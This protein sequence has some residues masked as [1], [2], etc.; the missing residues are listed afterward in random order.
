M[1]SK[2]KEAAGY[3]SGSGRFDLDA[4]QL[5]ALLNEAKRFKGE[6][7]W[8]DAWRRLGRNRGAWWS[9]VFL[10][11]F[12]GLSFFAPV[13]PLP[14]PMALDPQSEPQPPFLPW[15]AS[16]RL[17][18]NLPP[19]RSFEFGTGATSSLGAFADNAWRHRTFLDFQLRA[20]WLPGD[21]P[22]GGD[23]LRD[24]VKAASGR[25]SAVFVKDGDEPGTVIERHAVPLRDGDR[26]RVE[27]RPTGFDGTAQVL[28]VGRDAGAREAWVDFEVDLDRGALESYEVRTSG[29]GIELVYTL[30]DE[31]DQLRDRRYLAEVRGADGITVTRLRID[32]ER[33][34][35]SW[36][37]D[38]GADPAG[39]DGQTDAADD[40]VAALESADQID[41]Q[42][43]SELQVVSQDGE[44]SIVVRRQAVPAIGQEGHNHADLARAVRAEI[45]SRGSR[46]A[47]LEMS[48][49]DGIWDLNPLDRALVWVRTKVFGLWQT[50]PLLGTDNK[51]RDL[52][53]R[54]V[55]G[56]R[57]SIQVSLVATLCSLLIGVTYG[58]FSGLVGGRT[59][60][61]MM[62]IVDVLYSVPF[63]FV[64]I[65]LITLINEYRTDLADYGIGYMTVFYVVIGAIYWLTMARVVRGQVLSLKNQE[66]V[67]A[68][69][70]LGASTPRILFVHL[71][72][73]VLSIVIVYLT[74]TIPAV[75]LFEA[76]LSF[77]GLGVEPPKVSWGLLAVDGTEAIS[78]VK[79]F[80][81]VVVFPAMAM[82]STL[83]A[84]NILGDGLRD[85]LDPKLRGKD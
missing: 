5:Q 67:E 13:L 36:S 6:S 15:E 75:M 19:G 56:S 68:A 85:A 84:L 51:G 58:A 74:L 11:L 33:V 47:L 22:P 14:S 70:V 43:L 83:L 69:R 80:W 52:L 35:L 21:P 57:I 62:R 63:I 8:Q 48:H 29:D 31:G 82:G 72:P 30:G 2:H 23:E 4:G 41:L 59:D 54:I 28:V 24:L 79:T 66:F 1:A 73:N 12:V 45:A 17:P 3:D 7:L 9:L 60:N 38:G 61:L 50:G 81:W 20:E 40:L 16:P 37:V 78:A 76:F 26:A 65:F 25:S 39:L 53:A 64:V 18:E 44:R 49:L 71:V 46:A 34:P 42:H 77:L 27:Y 32:G 10:T 55:W